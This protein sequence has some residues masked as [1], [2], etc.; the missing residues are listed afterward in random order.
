MIESFA[1]FVLR[2]RW[3][4]IGLMLLLSVAATLGALRLRFDNSLEIWFVEGDPGI[5][6]YR[7]F[8][9]LFG[10]DE[11]LILA[12]ESDDVFSKDNLARIGRVE[13]ASRRYTCCD[14][15]NPPNRSSIPDWIR[16]ANSPAM[17]GRTS[18]T[19]SSSTRTSTVPL[20]CMP[21]AV[22]PTRIRSSVSQA[23]SIGPTVSAYCVRAR[24][25]AS[26]MRRRTSAGGSR[27]GMRVCERPQL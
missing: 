16:P 11:I 1:R 2:C 22:R 27:W 5:E 10:T 15:N 23:A 7:E 4:I 14:P 13:V 9:D 25:T 3:L 17:P 8:L 6:R 18:V 19:S 20:N 24:T 21:I 26:S 12:W